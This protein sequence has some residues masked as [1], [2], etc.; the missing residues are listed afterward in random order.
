MKCLVCRKEFEGG[1]CP[2]C[3]YPVVEGT[4]VDALM[5]TLRP[6]IEEYRRVFQSGIRLDLEICR[7]KEADGVVVLDR[8]DL[9]SFGTY[10]E[11]EGRITWL[12]QPFARIPDVPTLD[13]HLRLNLADTVKEFL[14]PVQN[15]TEA[16]LQYVG[17]ELSDDMYFRLLL[18]NDA[19][20]S[21]QSD[22]M[23]LD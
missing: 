1:V 16:S 20:A 8:K 10:P 6:Q 14:V 9:L 22:W 21:S 19:G 3:G 7:W 4:D 2:R 15:L 5:E 18:K 13:L 11:L 17:V 23:E 12:S